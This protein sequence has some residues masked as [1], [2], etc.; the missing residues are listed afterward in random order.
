[1]ATARE[2]A[3]ASAFAGSP[4]R[5]HGNS[6]RVA[7]RFDARRTR[8]SARPRGRFHAV[9]PASAQCQSSDAR[10]RVRPMPSAAQYAQCPYATRAVDAVAAAPPPPPPPPPP[11]PPPVGRLRR[12]RRE[13]GWY[14]S[15]KRGRGEAQQQQQQ[16]QALRCRPPGSSAVH[17]ARAPGGCDAAACVAARTRASTSARAVR[18]RCPTHDL[19][20][21]A[22]AKR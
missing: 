12:L 21:V 3:V 4:R 2:R 7:L 11:L 9:C 19:P 15:S 6:E 18:G 8:P 14:G 20:L 13:E 17:D 1:M 16:Q 10:G 22:L 5:E